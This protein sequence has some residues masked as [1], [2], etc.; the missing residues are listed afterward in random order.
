MSP[1]FAFFF[2][3]KEKAISLDHD[4]LNRKNILKRNYS[5]GVLYP[6]KVLLN[7]SNCG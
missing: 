6:L 1:S 2:F 3:L 5:M 4:G 7:Q